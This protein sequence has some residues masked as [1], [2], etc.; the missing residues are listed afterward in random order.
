MEKMMAVSFADLV[1]MTATLGLV[2]PPL[3]VGARLE[4]PSM[5]A[6]VR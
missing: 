3:A 4:I 5:L 2:L 6:P 1:R